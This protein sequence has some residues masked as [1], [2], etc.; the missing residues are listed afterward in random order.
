V[1]AEWLAG[2]LY[3]S[4]HD[5]LLALPDATRV[6]PSHGAGSACGKA[7]STEK[8]STIGDERRSNY[9][10]A[11]MS[12]S[13][14]VDV[15]TQG[16]SAAPLYFAFD[17]TLNKQARQTL[18]DDEPPR[19]LD[20]DAFAGARA[21]GAV[22]LDARDAADFATG[23][24]RGSI[25][26]GLGGRFAEYAGGIIRA[27]A[28]IVLVTEPGTE[29]EAKVRLARIGFD[30]VVGFLHDP[31]RQIAEHPEEVERASRLTASALADAMARL[32][33]QVVDVR[34]SAEYA[35]GHLPTA[36][37]VALA[38]LVTRAS[39]LDAERPT[40]LYC[41]GGYRS[42]IGASYLRSIGFL[43]VSDLLGGYNAWATLHPDRVAV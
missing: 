28:P 3:H 43:D 6:Y 37:D 32:D 42:S 30:S 15:V 23:H 11:P 27:G 16:Q 10:L 20:W 13:E 24:L 14:F 40:V 41:G 34:G 7:L 2:Q 25:N 26:V 17:A 1:T 18:R 12:E 21:A 33:V 19:P 5:K 8:V 35:A 29:L 9:A 38:V 39:D 31:Q 22:V 36:L 4:L